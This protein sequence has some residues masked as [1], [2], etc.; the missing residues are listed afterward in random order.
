MNLQP[1]GMTCEV[2]ED[3]PFPGRVFETGDRHRRVP[4]S[5]FQVPFG[6]ASTMAI[7]AFSVL[8]TAAEQPRGTRAPV[9]RR[10]V[11]GT[12]GAWAVGRR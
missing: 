6:G 12:V 9:F 7:P 3:R 4:A 10:A 1:E 2:M 11:Q 8:K 5:G